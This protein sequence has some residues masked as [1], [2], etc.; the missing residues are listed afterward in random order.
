M[1]IEAVVKSNHLSNKPYLDLDNLVT[2]NGLEIV[3][4]AGSSSDADKVK[5]YCADNPTDPSCVCINT[6]EV[7]IDQVKNAQADYDEKYAEWKKN[8]DNYDR[9]YRNA[10]DSYNQRLWAFTNDL[11]NWSYVAYANYA[12]GDPKYDSIN[13]QISSPTWDHGTWFNYTNKFTI[14]HKPEYIQ[15]QLD[16]WK[17]YNA[18]PQLQRPQPIPS[19]TPLSVQCCNNTITSTT[20]ISNVIQSCNQSIISNYNKKPED[21]KPDDKKTDDTKPDVEKPN[22]KKPDDTKHDDKK[23]DDTKPDDKKPDVKKP[24]V[25]SSNYKIQIAIAAIAVFFLLFFAFLIHRGM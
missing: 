5:K 15:T 8:S 18:I 6:A 25:T 17:D 10:I 1:N 21:K 7:L 9:D 16:R 3:Y 12:D 11:Q 14:T 13:N 2:P 4:G 22:D 24:D 23:P 19:S 20:N